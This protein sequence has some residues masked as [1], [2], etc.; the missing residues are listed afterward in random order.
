MLSCEEESGAIPD[1]KWDVVESV[2]QDTGGFSH[3]S[4]ASVMQ[5]VDVP[6][7]GCEGNGTGSLT[8]HLQ[9]IMHCQELHAINLV[10]K[11]LYSQVN[12]QLD[13]NGAST[14]AAKIAYAH[15]NIFDL[16]SYDCDLVYTLDCPY[17]C[18][19]TPLYI[20]GNVQACQSHQGI[21]DHAENA[22]GGAF[23]GGSATLL[24][25]KRRGDK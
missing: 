7:L 23:D 10:Y 6:H 5:S 3:D 13:T 17:L 25:E 9:N 1:L 11:H 14:Y 22:E 18:R 19:I 12:R 20:F 8:S 24:K 16:P 21:Q 15:M 2:P 4:V